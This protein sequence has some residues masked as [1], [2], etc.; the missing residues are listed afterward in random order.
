MSSEL[1]KHVTVVWLLGIVMSSTRLAA[2]ERAQEIRD[3]APTSTAVLRH[4][5]WRA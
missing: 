3:R 1:M 4:V 2:D 5:P